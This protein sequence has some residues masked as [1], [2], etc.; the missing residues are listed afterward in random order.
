MNI[1]ECRYTIVVQQ[2][3]PVRDS[4]GS[5]TIT[6]ADF[7]TLRAS[8][9]YAGGTKTINTEE[10]FTSQTLIFETHYRP[11]E[12][13]MII[14]FNAKKYRILNIEEVGYKTSLKITTEL[15]NE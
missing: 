2:K 6:W 8:V 10:I 12:T 3:V 15:I 13:D 11:I 14:L 1:G 9:K 7:L 4:Y 5:E